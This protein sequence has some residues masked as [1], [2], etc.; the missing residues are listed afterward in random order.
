MKMYTRLGLLSVALLGMLLVGC[1]TTRPED[2]PG[3]KAL[4]SARAAVAMAEQDPGVGADAPLSLKKAQD[5]L[6]RAEWKWYDEGGDTD[7]ETGAFIANYAYLAQRYAEVAQAQ[8]RSAEANRDW[9]AALAHNKDLAAQARAMSSKR[10]AALK[11]NRSRLQQLED[12]VARLRAQG[13]STYQDQRGLVISMS[14][15]RFAFDS[16]DIGAQYDSTLD[17]VASYL[18]ENGEH[19]VEVDGYTDSVGTSAYNHDLSLRRAASVRRALISRGANPA[20][21]TIRGYGESSP[22]ASNATASGRAQNRRVEMVV[23]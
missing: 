4:Q 3:Y 20:Q 2:V 21:I 5:M 15:V 1:G 19:R 12:E 9:Q 8:A 22:V 11:K 17:K 16:A 10:Q 6:S 23:N 7:E 13:V 18:R 14:G